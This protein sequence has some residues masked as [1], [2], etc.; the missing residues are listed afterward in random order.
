VAL[1]PPVPAQPGQPYILSFEFRDYET[2]ALTDPASVQLD[3]T[4]GAAVG[5]VSDTAGPYTW[6][7]VLS[8]QVPNAVWRT[9][10]GQ[11]SGMWQVPANAAS[12]AYVANWT[13]VY[14]PNNDTFLTVENFAILQGGPYVA[15]PSGDIGYW[16][17]SLTYQPAYAPAPLSITLGATD[18][19]GI[20]WVLKKVTGWDSPPAVGA[21]VQRAADHGG[22]PVPQYYGPRLIVL[23]ILASAPD[24]ATRDLARALFQQVIPISDLATFVYNEPIPKVAY[25]RRNAEAQVAETYPTLVDVEFQVALVAPDPRKY[26]VTPQQSSIITPAAVQTPVSLP[27]TLPI[28]FPGA[29]V[30][31][32]MTLVN[33]GTFETRPVLTVNGPVTNPAIVNATAGAQVSFTGLVMGVNDVLVVDMDARQAYLNGN[34]Y[35]ADLNSGWW[36]LQPGPSEVYLSGASDAGAVLTATWASAWM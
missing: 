5:L 3:I 34:F 15:V 1:S 14:G 13:A 35:P 28:V 31:V 18:G 23:D 16:T 22:W 6:D 36:V 4:Y 19:N 29:S 9:G 20:T 21:V 17:G 25:V 11:Y 10:T 2:G 32:P 8:Y 30:T 24:Q 27:W 7:G 12:G 26:A 33:A